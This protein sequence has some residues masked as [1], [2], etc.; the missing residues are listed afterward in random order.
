MF[1]TDAE[2][3]DSRAPD[4]SNLSD[5]YDALHL[6]DLLNHLSDIPSSLKG[7]GGLIFFSGKAKLEI[8]VSYRYA[9]LRPLNR[10]TDIRADLL[11]DS[12]NIN[13][14]RE[15]FKSSVIDSIL[16]N[17]IR[18]SEYF[19]TILKCFGSIIEGYEESYR[20]YIHKFSVKE[21]KKE[22]ETNKLELAQKIHDVMSDLNKTLLLIPIAVVFM[23]ARIDYKNPSGLSSIVCIV[24]VGIFIGLVLLNLYNHNK[25]LSFVKNEINRQKKYISTHYSDIEADILPSYEYLEQRIKYQTVI[26]RCVGSCLWFIFFMMIALYGYLHFGRSLPAKHRSENSTTASQCSTVRLGHE[27]VLNQAKKL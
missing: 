16:M 5:Y 26:R 9:D 19:K 23:A 1:Y 4:G 11:S 3:I 22:I 13:E 27:A 21:I 12:V 25:T 14:K 17:N 24:A 2:C 20:I 18:P 10:L 6:V 15:L 8:E 7:N